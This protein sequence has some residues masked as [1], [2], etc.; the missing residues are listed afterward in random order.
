MRMPRRWMATFAA[1]ALISTLA[2]PA[3]AVMIRYYQPLP[4][5]EYLGDPDMPDSVQ[6]IRL[7]CAG[8]ATKLLPVNGLVFV[9]AMPRSTQNTSG[10]AATAR[11][12]RGHD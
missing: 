7:L 2:M 5:E 3:E 8:W 4:G 1:V 6:M 10:V 12:G 9:V 11:A